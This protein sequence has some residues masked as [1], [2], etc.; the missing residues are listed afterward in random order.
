MIKI[1]ELKFDAQG[2]IPAIVV[3]AES[4]ISLLKKRRS[5]FF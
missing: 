5:Y 2:L 4:N 1:E 3:D